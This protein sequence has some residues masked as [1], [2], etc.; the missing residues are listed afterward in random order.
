MLETAIWG[1][2]IAVGRGFQNWMN[3][4]E[5][6]VRAEIRGSDETREVG[7]KKGTKAMKAMKTR[8]GNKKGGGEEKT[9]VTKARLLWVDI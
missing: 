3:R 2:M 8:D 9:H 1:A 5:S 4:D 6:D 7:T